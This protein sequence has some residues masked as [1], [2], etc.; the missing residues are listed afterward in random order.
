MLKAIIKN[1]EECLEICYKEHPEWRE[2]KEHLAELKRGTNEILAYLPDGIFGREWD[3]DRI[4][5]SPE[6]VGEI[7]D[8][9]LVNGWV[10]PEAFIE[11][12]EEGEAFVEKTEEENNFSV[13]FD[14]SN[15]VIVKEKQTMT[16][17]PGE[18]WS[19]V[20]YGNEFDTKGEVQ[21]YIEQLDEDA[22]IGN[23]P[24]KDILDNY[25]TDIIAKKTLASRTSNE[26]GDQIYD[27]LVMLGIELA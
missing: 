14:G 16:L 3:V 13:S 8:Y 26:N 1:K 17:K 23:V 15:F 11:K 9:I 5:T 25:S 12:R 22:V 6:D 19:I 18:F 21:E 27:V 2:D 10:V 24:L 20:R 4:I 7:G